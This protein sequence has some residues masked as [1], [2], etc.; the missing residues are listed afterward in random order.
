MTCFYQ[1]IK[2]ILDLIMLFVLP[3]SGTSPTWTASCT[4]TP[5]TRTTTSWPAS[6]TSWD[7]PYFFKYLK[8]INSYSFF[9][10]PQGPARD[11]VGDEAHHGAPVRRLSQHARRRP[12]RE[13]NNK[14][15]IFMF[16]L[17]IMEHLLLAVE[18]LWKGFLLQNFWNQNC[19]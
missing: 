16:C 8:N 4:A 18:T 12:G 13:I 7:F 1:I 11:W 6:G 17:Q 10:G 2:K 15:Y 5:P 3:I 14:L 9:A 19:T